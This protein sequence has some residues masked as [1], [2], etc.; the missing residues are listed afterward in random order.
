LQAVVLG[1]S[2]GMLNFFPDDLCIQLQD[3]ASGALPDSD[4]NTGEPT[5]AEIRM[6]IAKLK[7]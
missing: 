2:F 3:V 7:K 1:L 4:V 5:V 6:A